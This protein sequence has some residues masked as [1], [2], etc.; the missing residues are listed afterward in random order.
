[1][2]SN[3][4]ASEGKVDASEWVEKEVT[5]DKPSSFDESIIAGEDDYNASNVQ[6]LKGL[7]AVRRRPGM[8]IGDTDD[9][10]GLHHMVFEVVDNSV[11][12]ALIG[13][14][15]DVDVVLHKDNSVSVTDNGRGIPVDHHEEEDMPAAQVIMTEL[16]SGAKFDCSSYKIS[17][18]LHG[19]GVSVVNALSE[20]L[21]LEIRRDG[22]IYHQEYRRGEPFTEFKK[23]G[24]TSLT[25]TTITFKPDTDIFTHLDFSFDV[26]SRRLRQ[27]SFLNPGLKI[28][29]E[30]ER[31]KKKNEFRYS[32]GLSSFVSFLTKNKDPLF[33]PPVHFKE[34]KEDIQVEIALQ[35]SDAYQ[36]NVHCFTN[37]VFNKDGGTHVTGLRRALTR[38]IN[39]YGETHK[40]FKEIKSNLSGDDVR[41][42]LTCVVSVK[43]PDPKFN[44]QT[45]DRLV[46]S[47]VM[48]VVEGVTGEELGRFLEEN[49]KVA[50]IIVE[51]AVT[52]ARARVAARKA[53]ELVQRKGALDAQGLP[54][55]LADC[56]ERDPEKAE[57]FIVEGDSAGGSA[58][59]GRDRAFQAILPLRGKILNVEKARFE[60]M[61]SSQELA[62]LITAMGTGIGED[63]YD[64]EKLRYQTII[65]MTDADVDGSHIRTLLLTFFHRIMPDIIERGNLFIAQPPLYK[66]KKGKKVQ[67][68]KNEKSLEE[69]ILDGGTEGIDVKVGDTLLSREE[70]KSVLMQGKEY[71]SILENM[72]PLVNPRVLHS[73]VYHTDITHKQLIDQ[74]PQEVE[75]EIK[76][77]LGAARP[78]FEDLSVESTEDEEHGGVEIVCRF[79]ERG[80]HVRS[81]VSFELLTRVEFDELRG[82]RS[83]LSRWEPPYLVY[84]GEELKEEFHRLDDFIRYVENRGKQGIYIQRYKGLGEMNPDQLWETTMDPEKRNLLRIRVEDAVAADQVFTILM[85]D[86]VEPRREFIEANALNVRNLDI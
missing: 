20:W 81:R 84:K 22:G 1:M 67:Y 52:A 10:T 37:N 34:S 38:V 40:L 33:E 14:C 79:K 2:S 54:G 58:K 26:L 3:S 30:D 11:D 70:V 82:I 80:I 66:I 72:E 8:Y 74:T 29:L 39:S 47:E 57:L 60:K 49:P 27:L 28:S 55:K 31:T 76:K 77:A 50:K 15:T 42:G 51:K 53:R 17:G 71:R 4:D 59:Q 46:S 75:D 64:I 48:G 73:L 23:T 35:W 68:L 78:P 16:H 85:G 13:V 45:K 41:E 19:V 6:V 9:G 24:N 86:H 83:N 32:G 62:T 36:E 43:H 18:G 63:S 5:E 56:Q 25:G 44:S 65:I 21:R 12:E 7:E 61:L 69:Y